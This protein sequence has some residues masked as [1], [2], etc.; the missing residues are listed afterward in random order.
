MFFFFHKRALIHARVKRGD[1]WCLLCDCGEE[2]ASHIFLCCLFMRNVAF[3]CERDINLDGLGILEF[4]AMVK[5]SLEGS[6]RDSSNNNG[7]L[8]SMTLI[9]LFYVIWQ[10]RNNALHGRKLDVNQS[11]RRLEDAFCEFQL[12]DSIFVSLKGSACFLEGSFQGKT[13][14]DYRCSNE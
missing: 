14:G 9:N 5:K 8:S 6:S 3:A 4:E 13:Q 7:V 2:S 1:I 10:E 12:E 11:V